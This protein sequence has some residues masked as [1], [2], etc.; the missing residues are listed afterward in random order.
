MVNEQNFIMAHCEA[1]FK[2]GANHSI[3]IINSGILPVWNISQS[4]QPD[5][6]SG[7]DS[8]GIVEVYPLLEMVGGN[9]Q[10]YLSGA[11]SHGISLVRLIADIFPLS[12]KI[13]NQ[14]IWRG[15]S[16]Q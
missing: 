8:S 14:T 1:G 6:L 15:G 11:A 5:R 2:R 16:H 3:T 13:R 12:A 7:T 9:W 10:T 4:Q